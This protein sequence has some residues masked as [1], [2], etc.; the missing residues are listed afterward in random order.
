MSELL[1]RPVRLLLGATS[2]GVSDRRLHE[3]V[4]GDVVLITGASSGVGRASA[5]RLAA[6]GATVLLV[7]RRAELLEE[8]HEEI[9]AAGGRAFVHPCDLADFERVGALATEV[10]EQ[11]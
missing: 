9:L 4:D 10:L 7:A 3:A 6:A 11:H 5:V 1:P 2:R 8:V